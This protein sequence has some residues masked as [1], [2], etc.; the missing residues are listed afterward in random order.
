MSFTWRR[1]GAIS[2]KE[3]RDY[4]S[5]RFAIGPMAAT[6]GLFI[7]LPASQLIAA[8]TLGSTPPL[9]IVALISLN[10]ITVP[11]ALAIGLAAAPLAIDLP[12]WRVVAAMP[13]RERLVTG[14]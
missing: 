11:A 6:P 8:N 3:L 9:A 10:V 2:H 12:A 7:V 13:D 5:N 1:V 14:R 4:R